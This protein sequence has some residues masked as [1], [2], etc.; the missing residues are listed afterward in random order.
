M[1]FPFMEFLTLSYFSTKS[2]VEEISVWKQGP[3]QIHHS[4]SLVP[5]KSSTIYSHSKIPCFFPK[6]NHIPA[7]SHRRERWGLAICAR[8]WRSRWP[9]RDRRDQ[10]GGQYLGEN[11][12]RTKNRKTV[13]I[14]LAYWSYLSHRQDRKVEF[15]EKID[16]WE[17]P[18]GGL[19][20]MERL[21][22]KIGIG[23]RNF[24]P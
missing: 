6:E 22:A 19:Q 20:A 4:P 10:R 13:Q 14:F 12:F 9:G 15:L 1:K 5:S 11:L 24:Q 16:R 21:R 17:T 7:A 2:H 8:W 3:C 23:V 18:P